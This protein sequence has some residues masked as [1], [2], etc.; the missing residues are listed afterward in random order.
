MPTGFDTD[1]DRVRYQNAKVA[2]LVGTDDLR[3]STILD[4]LLESAL[5]Q[6]IDVVDSALLDF[7]ADAWETTSTRILWVKQK[8]GA[9]ILNA[10]FIAVGGTLYDYT[11]RWTNESGLNPPGFVSQEIYV[12]DDNNTIVTYEVRIGR[13]WA[14]AKLNGWTSFM[15]LAWLTTNPEGLMGL[16]DSSVTITADANVWQEVAVQMIY[17]SDMWL[18]IEGGLGRLKLDDTI[19]PLRVRPNTYNMTA[20]L[21]ISS[22]C[23]VQNRSWDFTLG[24]D[25]VVLPAS[26]IIHQGLDTIKAQTVDIRGT[27]T[28]AGIFARGAVTGQEYSVMVRCSDTGTV[29][30]LHNVLLAIKG[31]PGI[32]LS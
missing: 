19:Q 6:N 10:P 5:F 24:V 18:M 32:G 2:A 15:T 14:E 20:D 23:A 9:S 29:I 16:A 25:G 26:N 27:T 17:T 12:E 8:D 22:S 28:I 30:D 21:S 4:A 7:D 31:V 11:V 1:A 13:T 3:A